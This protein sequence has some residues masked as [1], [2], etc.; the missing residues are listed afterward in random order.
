[1]SAAALSQSTVDRTDNAAKAAANPPEHAQAQTPKHDGATSA[2]LPQFLYVLDTTATH[3]S[4]ARTHQMLVE[5][6]PRDFTFKVGEPLKLALPIAIKFLRI[7]EFQRTDEDGLIQPYHRQPKQP[8]ELG[9]GERFAI[10]DHQTVADYGELSNV[11]LLQRAL[12]LPGGE[13]LKDQSRPTLIDFIVKTTVERRK[14]NL[15]NQRA[16]AKA[17]Q[18]PAAESDSD[19][20]LP[21]PEA[22]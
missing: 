15:E 6:Q 2:S 10:S 1:M 14:A 3:K 11:A 8:H 21:E 20:F 16:A 19:E 12:E 17:K 13:L 4:G 18:Q 22:E 7:P 9:A 5:K